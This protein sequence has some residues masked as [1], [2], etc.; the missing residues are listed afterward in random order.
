MLTVLVFLIILTAA[1]SLPS[2][3]SM[4]VYASGSNS[5]NP[6]RI[7]VTQVFSTSSASVNNIFTYTF[8]PLKSGSPMPGRNTPNTPNEYIFTIAGNDDI[9]IGPIS[10]HQEGLYQYTLSQAVRAAAGYSYDT[11]VYRIDVHVDRELNVIILIFNANN[12]K[13]ANITFYNSYKSPIK[14]SEP[15]ATT[16]PPDTTEPATK[17]PVTES[18]TKPRPTTEPTTPTTPTIP[19]IPA[20]EK[21]AVKPTEIPVTESTIESMSTNPVT[22][23]L[24]EPAAAIESP[25]GNPATEPMN[26][27]AAERPAEPPHKSGGID[28]ISPPN[29]TMPGNKLTPYQDGYIEFDKD[30]FSVGIWKW[31]END[32]TWIFHENPP[33]ELP[34]AGGASNFAPAEYIKNTPKTGDESN[35]PLYITLILLGGAAA[36]SATVYLFVGGKR[37]RKNRSEK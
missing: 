5:N 20:T 34:E 19:A 31:N 26:K 24:T 22:E 30:G 27:S 11:R 15:A 37:K 9:H 17:Q 18:T 6:I 28:L 10:Y 3:L 4:I 2:L 25:A 33:Y 8:K 13:T 36:V 1:A 35:T 7:T 32:E 21:P 16:N 12:K 29:P 14:P 23:P